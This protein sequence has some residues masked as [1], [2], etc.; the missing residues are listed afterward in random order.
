MYYQ[1]TRILKTVE[2]ID[3]PEIVYNIFQDIHICCTAYNN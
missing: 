1:K 2:K 3:V